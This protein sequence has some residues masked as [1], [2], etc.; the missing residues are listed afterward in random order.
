MNESHAEVARLLISVGLK[1]M[2]EA[3]SLT[4]HQAA[5]YVDLGTRLERAVVLGERPAPPGTSA[6]AEENLSPLEQIARE[7]AGGA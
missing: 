5:R 3:P 6:P 4:P 7:L 2:Q 1:A